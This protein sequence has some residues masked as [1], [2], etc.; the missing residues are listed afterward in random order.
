MNRFLSLSRD[1]K[2]L[3]GL[4]KISGFKDEMTGKVITNAFA[5][6]LLDPHDISDKWTP[7]ASIDVLEIK[8]V[9]QLQ[10]VVC[11]DASARVIL[12]F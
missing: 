12:P 8:P 4:P 7:I 1:P 6:G 10:G 5:I 2:E 3:A 9:I 11:W